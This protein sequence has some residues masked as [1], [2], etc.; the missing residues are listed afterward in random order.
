M[1][2]GTGSALGNFILNL[3]MQMD[4]D[5]INQIQGAAT[6]LRG[7]LQNAIGV[8]GITLSISGIK[9]FA[10]ECVALASDAFE[11][12]NKFNTV[13]QSMEDKA[14]EMA[15]AIANETQRSIYDIKK[16]MADMQNLFVGFTD[17][18][19]ESRAEMAELSD[20]AIRLA[21]NMASF[22]NIDE[23]R[24]IELMTKA[25]MGETE[26]AKTLG[27]VLNDMTLAQAM[28]ANGMGG[29]FK[30]LTESEKILVRLTAIQ[31]QS[32]DADND[33]VRS[34]GNYESQMRS[35]NGA[36]KDIRV[37][38]GNYL[39]PVYRKIN[40]VKTVAVN[41]VR[42]WVEAI[43]EF[44]GKLGSSIQVVGAFAGAIIATVG[45]MHIGSILK[46][47]DGVKKLAATFTLG[48][49]KAAGLFAG[50]L[51]LALII[52]D[53]V[54]FL[55]G[56]NSLL[57]E[58][59]KQA[60]VDVDAARQ[61]F[62]DI[63]DTLM[64]IFN[65]AFETAGNSVRNVAK[66]AS[67]FW[68]AY[69]PEISADIASV[70]DWLANHLTTAA[71][72]AADGI[73]AFWKELTGNG[74][75]AEGVFSTFESIYDWIKKITPV[76]GDALILAWDAFCGIMKVVGSVVIGVVRILGGIGRAL[77]TVMDAIGEAASFIGESLRKLFNPDT[78]G[79]GN[80]IGS[81]CKAIGDFIVGLSN[82]IADAI[83]IIGK[84]IGMFIS[85]GGVIVG[86]AVQCIA[87]ATQ[88]LKDHQGVLVILMGVLGAFVA[89][90]LV[91]NAAQIANA[92][93]TQAS[94]IAHGIA[95]RMDAIHTAYLHL[96]EQATHLVSKA[97]EIMTRVMNMG[98]WK[99]KLVI[100]IIGAVVGVF[101][102]LLAKFKSFTGI[103]EF[104]GDKIRDVLS[105][106]GVVGEVIQAIVD[107]VG[108]AI[109]WVAGL[110]DKLF[111]LGKSG[112]NDLAEGLE[113]G[114]EEGM[115][116]VTVTADA[117]GNAAAQGLSSATAEGVPQAAG[118]EAMNGYAEGMET[119]APSAAEAAEKLGATVASASGAAATESVNAGLEETLYGDSTGIEESI[120]Q[121]VTDVM[122]GG[123]ENADPET[124]GQ[125]VADTI[126]TSI[127]GA[128]TTGT[129]EAFSEYMGK[130]M[131]D[132]PA[133]YDMET[134]TE[135]YDLSDLEN[136]E[137][138]DFSSM[139]GM[140]SMT[141]DFT[142]VV[143]AIQEQGTILGNFL[144]QIA[145]NILTAITSITASAEI[146]SINLG[147]TI[148]T[149][150]QSVNSVLTVAIT[151]AVT[152]L[153]TRVDAF[154]ESVTVG[155]KEQQTF[156]NT[157]L[158]G[159][160]KRLLDVQ[161]GIAAGLDS[162]GAGISN[163]V[164]AVAGAAGSLITGISSSLGSLL[165]AYN[166]NTRLIAA[167]MDRL[168]AD[169]QDK[170]KQAQMT[171][172]GNATYTAGGGGVT[173]NINISNSY[174]GDTGY[175]RTAEGTSK[176]AGDITRELARGMSYVM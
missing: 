98:S 124:L 123:V 43:T 34:A 82:T 165:N 107:K 12:Q 164:S 126:G 9:N 96:Q 23:T 70:V 35:L 65:P 101:A 63:G 133:G 39:L 122:T 27:A 127:E 166:Y 54:A 171:T 66:G 134:G 31:M 161:L 20:D 41:K 109:K 11:V 120:A 4:P 42:D 173:Q 108:G 48:K 131:Q 130:V 10:G 84:V 85:L 116:G 25:M 94:A 13:Y 140:P 129:S 132:V 77:S 145:N 147:A 87:W 97:T 38:I 158:S 159:F 156:L 68:K 69:A 176:T 137:G 59:L 45:I 88:A 57:G 29:K 119:S 33:C 92:V 154:R 44:S 79:A 51:L 1:A 15:E 61:K 81:A 24:A 36:L 58:L 49:L 72:E 37:T 74:I 95:G 105:H 64:K 160:F 153:A 60:G 28:A 46:F 117:V 7:W 17:Y 175:Q 104:I 86:V 115:D 142:P 106:W 75:S 78:G 135:G 14:E 167:G 91:A 5:S 52:D 89:L 152:E 99:L 19:D 2:G 16:Y 110:L 76:V 172:F 174:N 128:D 53:F 21:L 150:L 113:E 55:Q 163:I 18:S 102:A 151:T 125:G 162:I 136:M 50:V 100:A 121:G 138:Y 148:D 3:M 71:Q 112:G 146:Q 90:L 149:V 118:A 30:D 56:R 141:T 170:L 47:A 62:L 114:L 40:E 157:L 143:T 111:H 22:S 67:D 83:E 155:L 6:R 103:V 139:E 80:V 144:S 93:A 169:I 73:S 32:K 168:G 8:F 26:C